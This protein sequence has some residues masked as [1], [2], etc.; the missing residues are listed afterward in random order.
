VR[1]AELAAVV[2][3]LDAGAAAG[4]LSSD[5]LP[6]A[7]LTLR[8]NVETWSADALPGPLSG[9]PTAGTRSSSS[10]TPAAA[11]KCIRSAASAARTP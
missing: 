10:T 11:C 1:R 3:T 6:A 7:L 5:R 2:T 9:A 4:E 8:R